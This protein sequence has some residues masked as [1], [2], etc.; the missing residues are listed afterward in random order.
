[1]LAI[2][3]VGV[4]S[5]NSSALDLVLATILGIVG[6]CMRRLDYPLAPVILGLVLGTLLEQALRQTLMISG[7]SLEIFWRS[8]IAI[9]L[10]VMAI[11]VVGLPK[12][13]YRG[14][15]IEVEA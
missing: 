14:A 10:F 5:V 7:G 13:L 15:K 9:G 11:A 2:S 4:Y 8:P 3:F 6:Y 1:V 12:L